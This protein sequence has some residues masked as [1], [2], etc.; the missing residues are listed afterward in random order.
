[1]R[2]KVVYD[3]Y[4]DMA[5]TLYPMS[6]GKGNLLPVQGESHLSGAISVLG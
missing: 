4:R 6:Y 3:K 1:M 5:F 2:Y